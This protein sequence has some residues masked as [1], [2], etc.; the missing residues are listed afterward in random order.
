MHDIIGRTLLWVGAVYIDNHEWEKAEF[1][2]QTSAQ[3]N[4]QNSQTFYWLGRSLLAQHHFFQASEA[5]ATA[6]LLRC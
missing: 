6:T 4:T 3:L 1:A 5:F 2:L